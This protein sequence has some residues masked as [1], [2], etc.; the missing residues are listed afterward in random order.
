MTKPAHTPSVEEINKFAEQFR[1]AAVPAIERMAEQINAFQA[2]FRP[3]IE[4]HQRR[5]DLFT[6]LAPTSEPCHCL[7][8]GH[9]DHP[10]VCAGEAEFGLGLTFDSPT[11]GPTFV[12]MCR[13]CHSVRTGGE[14]RSSEPE[15]GE[16]EAITETCACH[17]WANHPGT[18]GVCEAASDPGA[19]IDG[20]PACLGCVAATRGPSVT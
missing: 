4:L 18:H 1:A 19:I 13:N 14:I 11:V 12:R 20:K 7:C 8:G 3:L 17:C 6:Q 2:A 10:G 15:I 9:P 5:P 16:L